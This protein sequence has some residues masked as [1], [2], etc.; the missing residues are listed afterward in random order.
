MHLRLVG[1][2]AAGSARGADQRSFEK[3]ADFRFRAWLS[4]KP[5]LSPLK[6]F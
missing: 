4:H 5:Q 6:P 2:L 3:L 1:A